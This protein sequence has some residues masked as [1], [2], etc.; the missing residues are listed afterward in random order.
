[1]K[2]ICSKW[3]ITSLLL[4]SLLFTI[5]AQANINVYAASS[6]TNVL[7]DIVTKFNQ[8]HPN[9]PPIVTVFAGSSSLA[10]QIDNGAPADI[11]ISANQNWMNYLVENKRILSQNRFNLV[12]NEL[13]LIG[14]N[15]YDIK[16]FELHDLH[17]WKK[18]LSSQERLAIGNT[19]AVPA[20]MYAK[21]ALIALGIWNDVNTQ[22]APMGNVRLVLALVERGETPIGIVY[23]TDAL[24]S[25]EVNIIS[26]FADNLHEP[27]EY[28]MAWLND[29]AETTVF[30]S[31]L[32]SSTAQAIFEQYGFTPMLAAPSSSTMDQ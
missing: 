20:G 7:G 29:K 19:D 28:P 9:S 14:S 1:M 12:R 18:I 3:I 16:P 26:T 4:S 23:K 2:T 31:F 8:E 5:H 22:L 17:A 30:R 6:L 32:Y 15:H 24:T 21:Q 25:K 11:F 13:V 27:I 10:R